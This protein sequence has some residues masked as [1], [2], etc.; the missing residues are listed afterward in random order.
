MTSFRKALIIRERLG[1]AFSQLIEKVKPFQKVF[2]VLTK[3]VI[4][5]RSWVMCFFDVVIRMNRNRTFSK[6]QT[7]ISE[8]TVE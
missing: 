8:L 5:S 2:Q 4:K 7:S 6:G 3:R 1:Q